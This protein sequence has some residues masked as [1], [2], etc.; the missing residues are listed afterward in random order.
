MGGDLDKARVEVIRD[1]LKD[2]ADTIRS[3]DRKASYIIAIV[4]VTM[5][6]Y[7][8]AIIKI[9][10]L[11]KLDEALPLNFI[12]NNWYLLYP[13]FFFI[14]A[15]IFLFESY[16][17]HLNP[18]KVLNKQDMAFGSNMFFF[19]S[20]GQNEGDAEE[21]S[22]TFIKRTADIK[23]LIKILYIEIFKLSYIRDYKIQ[24]L[25]AANILTYIAFLSTLL[26]L[27]ITISL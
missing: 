25:K 15:L 18:K 26:T 14:L 7:I 11:G 5:S 8:F 17:P 24:L 23:G 4:F 19:D 9:K 22:D 6:S 21:L 16:S 12:T 13:L 3:Q 27:G 2:V 10:G 1:A 20:Q